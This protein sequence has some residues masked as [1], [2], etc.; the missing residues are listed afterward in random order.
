M[1]DIDLNEPKETRLSGYDMNTLLGSAVVDTSGGISFADYGV[2]QN[3]TLRIYD[4]PD[5]GDYTIKSVTPFPSYTKLVLDRALTTTLSGLH[6]LVFH[7]SSSAGVQR[8]LIRVTGID[9]LDSSMQ[10]VGTKI[11]YAKALGA[12]SNTFANPAHGIKIDLDDALLGIVGIPLAGGPPGANVNGKILQILVGVTTYTVTFAGVNPIPLSSIINQINAVVGTTIATTVGTNRL[13]IFPLIPT[14][15]SLVGGTNPASSALPALFGSMVYLRDDMLRSATFDAFTDYFTTQVI[16]PLD[17]TFDVLQVLDGTQ[18]G[19]YDMN[20]VYPFPGV[21]VTPPAGLSAPKFVSAKGQGFYPQSNVHFQVGARSLGTARVYFLE[22][23]TV[24]FDQNSL[25]E[26]E[27]ANGSKP[28]FKPDPTNEA[29][30][31]PPLPGGAK[32][33]DGQTSSESSRKYASAW[34]GGALV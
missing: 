22:P 32:P 18:V 20:Y 19:F 26:I 12:Y 10:P 6:Y 34:R 31:L 23:T 24:Q 1:I 5:A 28:R 11:P 16:P 7:A 8:P 2:A 25:F 17:L 33:L 27:L 3:D 4:G 21:T 29:Q 13:G 15:V 30:L 14:Q 9:L